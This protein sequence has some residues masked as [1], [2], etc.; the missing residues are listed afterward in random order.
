MFPGQSVLLECPGNG[1]G[2]RLDRFGHHA[3]KPVRQMLREQRDVLASLAQRGK[4]DRKDIQPVVQIVPEPVLSNFVSQVAIGG[5]NHPHVDV[6]RARA[7]ESLELPLLQDAQQL[8][9]ELDRKVTDLV[10]E[11]R[12]AMRDL[13]PPGLAGMR[14]GESAA[15]ASEQLALDERRRAEP[16]S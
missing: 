6:H 10:E 11:Q 9:L 7:S 13:E 1:I 2:N 12:P 15:L 14:T 16:H 8:R 4:R 5:G 3:R